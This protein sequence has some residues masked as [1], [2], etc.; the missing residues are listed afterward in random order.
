VTDFLTPS[1]P[2]S[3]NSDLSFSSPSIVPAT[4]THFRQVLAD[5]AR[6]WGDRDM[7]P[8]HVA[9]LLH[10]FP[11]TSLVALADDGIRGYI[12]GFVTPDR[13]GYIH[14]IATRDDTRGT[15]LGRRLYQAFADAA[16]KQGALTLKA[17]TTFDNDRSIALHRSL[18]FSPR[19]V[20]AYSG[21]GHDR[22]VFTRDLP[23]TPTRLV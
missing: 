1:S 18:G 13:V 17:I 21:P 9:A 12:F 15:G 23:P 14:L 7:R 19:E 20:E 6:Y 11:T 2:D 4:M 5:H 10:E 22:I 8:L 16:R 3:D